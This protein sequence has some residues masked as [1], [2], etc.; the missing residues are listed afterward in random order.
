MG[1]SEIPVM[2]GSVELSDASVHGRFQVLHNDHLEYILEA[3]KRCQHLWIGITK[4]DIDHLNPLGRHRERPE[5][6][7]LTLMRGLMRQSF[8]LS[9]F[10]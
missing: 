8:H 1:L 5:S 9:P 3:K 2:A 6:N 10:L 7:P 4:Y